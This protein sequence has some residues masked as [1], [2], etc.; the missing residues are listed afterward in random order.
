MKTDKDCRYMFTV[1]HASIFGMDW[2]NNC[3]DLLASF[4]ANGKLLFEIAQ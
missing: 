4:Q 2:F 1:Q 3:A